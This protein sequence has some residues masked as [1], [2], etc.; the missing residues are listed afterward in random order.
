MVAVVWAL[1]L[2]RLHQVPWWPGV[3]PGLGLCVWMVYLADRTL[4]SVV[5]PMEHLDIRHRFYRR[6]RWLLLGGILPAGF[7]TLAWLALWVVPGGLIWQCLALGML[8]TLYLSLYTARNRRGWHLLLLGVASL[9]ALLVFNVM[10]L[11]PQ[12]KVVASALIAGLMSLLWFRNIHEAFVHTVQKEAA[13]GLLFALGCGAWVHFVGTGGPLMGGALE[14]LLL[15]ALFTSNLTGITDRELELESPGAARS[16]GHPSLLV[17][18]G[19]L[20]AVVIYGAARGLIADRVVPLAWAVGGGIVLLA[21]L[22]HLRSRFSAEAY[23]VLADLAV[24]APAVVVWWAKG[25]GGA[26]ACCM[27]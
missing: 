10:P 8:I 20:C 24:L 5:A 1:A 13:G 17:F 21:V 9:G 7:G 6:Y 11:H 4:D 3:L 26:A 2:A 25:P 14:T 22:N 12:F 23:R 27:P 19:F 16:R 18:V 15:T